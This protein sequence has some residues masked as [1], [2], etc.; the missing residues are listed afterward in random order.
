M[1]KWTVKLTVHF[2]SFGPSTFRPFGRYTFGY[3][4]PSI[5]DHSTVHFPQGPSTF[6]RLDRPFSPSDRSFSPK[7]VFFRLNPEN[8]RFP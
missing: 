3:S 1:G 5:F 2:M 4:S 8:H 7:T 6:R